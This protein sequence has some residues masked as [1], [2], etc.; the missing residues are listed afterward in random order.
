M[1]ID[2]FRCDVAGGVPDDFW[3][4]ARRRWAGPPGLFML[5]EAEGPKY[6]ATF[7]MTYGWELHH[8]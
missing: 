5:A 8:S 3:V 7:D 4:E 2:G 6:H 1:N